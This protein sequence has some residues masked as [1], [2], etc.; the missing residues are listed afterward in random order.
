V[1]LELFVKASAFDADFDYLDQIQAS[2]EEEFVM[3]DHPSS[4]RSQ[5]LL[6]AGEY[7][8]RRKGVLKGLPVVKVEKMKFES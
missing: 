1:I 7:S 6:V 2:A 4:P 5:A 3:E 8:E